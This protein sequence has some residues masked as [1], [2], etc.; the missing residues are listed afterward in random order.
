MFPDHVDQGQEN[1]GH[2]DDSSLTS[3][4]TQTGVKNIEAH[5]PLSWVS[6]TFAHHN[7]LPNLQLHLLV[8]KEQACEAY[9]S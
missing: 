5:R 3:D 4:A 9:A 1:V 8:D 7:D 2:E 6:L